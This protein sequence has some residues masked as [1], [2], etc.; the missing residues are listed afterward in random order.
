[1]Y[2]V[3]RH[4]LMN[5]SQSTDHRTHFCTSERVKTEQQELLSY[6][7]PWSN[8]L[9]AIVGGVAAKNRGNIFHAMEKSVHYNLVK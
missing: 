2:N 5:L 9:S 1:M 7:C 6:F 4:R 3:I 8:C